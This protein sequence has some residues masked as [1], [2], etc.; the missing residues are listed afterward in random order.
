MVHKKK[1]PSNWYLLCN[2]C[3]DP[4]LFGQIWVILSKWQSS[5]G[6]LAKFGYK[7]NM[8]KKKG[9]KSIPLYFWLLTWTMFKNLEMGFK[10]FGRIMAM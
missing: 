8:E 10:K 1:I 2:L 6:S 3:L 7:L 5:I 4:P 9:S